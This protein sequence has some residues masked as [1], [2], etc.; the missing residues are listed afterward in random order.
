M[1]NW[2]CIEVYAKGGVQ[3]LFRDSKDAAHFR[4]DGKDIQMKSYAEFL[5]GRDSTPKL[6]SEWESSTIS[7]VLKHLGFEDCDFN[8]DA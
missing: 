8:F 2:N 1:R 5:N 7:N 6:H 4:I 3:Y